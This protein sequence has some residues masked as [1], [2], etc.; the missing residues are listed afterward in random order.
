MEKPMSFMDAVKVCLTEKYVNFSD[1]A[2]RSEYW[3]FVLFNFLI[4]A[5]AGIIFGEGGV[6]T[7]LISLALLLPGIAVSIRRLHDTGRSGWNLLWVL[8]PVIGWIVLIVFYVGD[9]QPGTN[10]WGPNP[11]QFEI[12]QPE[13]PAEEPVQEAPES[14][15][16]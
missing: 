7:G 6:V 1:R 11:K 13:E 16:E 8:L 10:Q 12:P 4:S 2:R 3:Y 14:T 9:S 15:E 5:A